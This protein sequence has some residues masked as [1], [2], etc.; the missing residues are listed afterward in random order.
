MKIAH[1]A[2][3]QDEVIIQELKQHLEHV[4][5]LCGEYM[6]PLGC[7]T[8]GYLAGLIHDLAKTLS[9][10]Q[11][12]M[13][14][15]GSG[16][17]DPGQKGGHA[18][19]GAVLLDKLAGEECANAGL[20]GM[21]ALQ[22]M[23]E[24]IFSHHAALPD[25]V[26]PKGEDGYL[27]RMQCEEEDLREM[28][29]Y[30]WNEIITREQFSALLKQSFS[31]AEKLLQKV[32]G[33]TEK[34]KEARFF[35]GCFQKMLLS[36]LIDSDWLDS[37]LNG[38]SELP[39]GRTV[40]ET[41][42]AG[43]EQREQL[44]LKFLENLE[45]YLRKM[46]VDSSRVNLWRNYISENCKEA[47]GRKGG[48]YTLSCPTGAGKTLA[49]LRFAL[50]HCVKQKKQ[51]I[52]YI[53]P[54]LSII[55]QTAKCVKTAL[56]NGDPDMP[57]EKYILELHSNAEADQGRGASERED[58]LE[59][60][61]WVQ[62]MAEPVVLTTMVRFLNTFFA[63]GTRN[64][65]PAHQFQD[66]VIIFD[67]I[68]TLPIKQIAIF[69]SLINFLSGM[70]GCT[71]VLCTATQPLLGELREPVY[72]VRLA[73]PAKLTEIPR[74]ATEAFQRVEIK[75]CL[76]NGG[77]SGEELGSFVWDRASETDSL[78][79]IMNT[80]QSALTIYREVLRRSDAELK[81][82]YLSTRLYA[83][84]RKE[85][86]GEIRECL[87]AGDKII[88]VSTQLIEAGIDFDFSCVIRALSGMDSV[89][90]AA[91]RCNREGKREKG[92]TYIVNPDEDLENLV[93][94]KDI[95]EGARE[96]HRLLCEF[97]KTPG[98][99][100]GDLLSD[101]AIHTY[102][103]YYFWTRQEEMLYSIPVGSGYTM[104]ELLSDNCSLVT[105]AVKHNA[106]KPKALNQSFRTASEHFHVIEEG[107][108]PVF[109]R[110][111][112]GKE[113]WEEVQRAR[114]YW[115]VKELL[116]EAQLYVVNVPPHE[117]KKLGEGR[118]VIQWDDRMG[119]YVL[120]EMYYDE[121]TGLSGEVSGD[122][123]QYLF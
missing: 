68:Q 4:A 103:Q 72:P 96:T 89:V 80:K 119:M 36:S 40:M 61:F 9:A 69:N 117:L 118:G 25:N 90:Q 13:E 57:A 93:H 19:G 14:A 108:D 121:R 113:I 21:F 107:G 51:K 38:G 104:Y 59:R 101:K 1:I 91:G 11:D 43:G 30:L 46:V 123:P 10:F 26:S 109:V 110:R 81:V 122:M 27:G 66:A 83:A 79:V 71:C 47:G 85:T 44:F 65:R 8:M 100:D 31:E 97:E 102:F 5:R 98:E 78:L 115:N 6:R 64:L 48:I 2:I 106:Y 84:H 29:D 39:E 112:R 114:D 116:K 42:L 16:L 53:I 74:E 62:R 52:F 87:A 99:F 28:E 49:S 88:V 86:I 95:R 41:G 60:S 3:R 56:Q 63:S 54:Y 24:A 77:Y 20:A 23:C 34:P 105:S 17:P 37:A 111:N 94:L 73:C 22:V 120:N 7:P 67:E 18:S 58:S 45:S 50:T 70:C 92:M 33:C 15:I 75:A 76:R 55:D 35:M 12:R 32:S 82:Y